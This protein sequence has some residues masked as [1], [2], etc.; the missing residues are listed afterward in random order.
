M[1]YNHAVNYRPKAKDLL[2]MSNV[3]D[4]IAKCDYYT[5]ALYNRA[6]VTIGISAFK[7]GNLFEVQ[8]YLS[9]ICGYAKQ[10]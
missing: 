4:I 5:Q 1:V 3:P 10:K 6:I 2:V 8:Q 9:E 7:N